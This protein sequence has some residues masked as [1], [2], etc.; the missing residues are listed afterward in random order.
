MPS[1]IQLDENLW[2]L[3]ICLQ[4]SDLKAIDFNAVGEETNLK[5]PA[6]RMRYTR[7]RRQIESGTL[8]GTHGTPFTGGAEKIAEALKK[9][10]RSSGQEGHKNDDDEDDIPIPKERKP[11]K[12][13]IKDEDSDEFET[14]G[15]EESGDSEDE[16]PLAKLSGVRFDR[17]NIGAQDVSNRLSINAEDPTPS[18]NR[19]EWTTCPP[20]MATALLP[21][22][23]STCDNFQFPSKTWNRSPIQVS[24]DDYTENSKPCQSG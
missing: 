20:V 11:G 12:N 8:I 9:R 16:M 18:Q 23:Y 22:S 19:V 17:G 14:D 7:L 21:T 4:K 13:V 5:P 6:A 24:H 15:S 1:K 10:K 2:F 3:Y